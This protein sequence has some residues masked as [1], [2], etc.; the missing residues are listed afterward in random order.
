MADPNAS[1]QAEKTPEE[2]IEGA[3]DKVLEKE[4]VTKEGE[5]LEDDDLADDDDDLKDDDDKDDDKV[6]DDELTKKLAPKEPS[7]ITQIN[8]DYPDL[9]KKH[10]ELKAA[11]FQ[12]NEFKQVFGTPAE[13]SE[14]AEKGELLDKLAT[15]STTGN[16]EPM[17]DL[18][19]E[20]DPEGLKRFVSNFL[21]TLN[22]KSPQLFMATITP[23]IRNLF[24]KIGARAEEAGDED[25]A[26]AVKYMNKAVFNKSEIP[27]PVKIETNLKKNEEL[28]AERAEL[29]SQREQLFY[30][31]CVDLADPVLDKSINEGLDPDNVLSEGLREDTIEK[32][33]TKVYRTLQADAS[34]MRTMLAMRKS[35]AA[36]GYSKEWQKKVARTVANAAKEIMPGIRAKEKKRLFGNMFD[37]NKEGDTTTAL[38]SNSGTSATVGG[39]NK[40]APTDIDWKT[41][42]L[43]DALD[44]VI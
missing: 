7:K 35:A 11:Y 38:P 42:S 27:T 20:T 31:N 15:E 24:A 22:K 26:L 36:N 5:D 30:Q 13:A 18:L 34:H 41:T 17:L 19:H 40:G 23:V 39:N 10:P 3:D 32:I 28:I 14:A 4:K 12:Y 1:G 44:K 6:D 21:P 25:L 9:F 43:R 29:S 33:R 8:K 2:I 16:P 37:K